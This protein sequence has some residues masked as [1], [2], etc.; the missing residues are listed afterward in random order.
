MEDV[1]ETLLGLEI[2]DEKDKIV[3][4]QKYARERWKSR[5]AKYNSINNLNSSY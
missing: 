3:D 4:M 5:K 1:I 2:I